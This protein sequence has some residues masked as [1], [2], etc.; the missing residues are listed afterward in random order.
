MLKIRIVEICGINVAFEFANI[1]NYRKHRIM[2]N[3]KNKKLVVKLLLLIGIVAFSI[4]GYQ[5]ISLF[6]QQDQ[7]LDAG[8]VW[9]AETC[10]CEED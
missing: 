2:N 10:T 9:N 7:C 6:I 3:Q 1:H 5:K 8:N 4:W